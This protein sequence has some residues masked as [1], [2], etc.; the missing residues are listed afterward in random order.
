MQNAGQMRQ[1]GDVVFVLNVLDHIESFIAASAAG[2]VGTGNKIR[3]ERREL[4]DR[5]KK[6]LRTLF[7]FGRKKFKGVSFLFLI[8]NF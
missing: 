8:K 2:A 4:S 5:F 1:A 7:R 3:F 6:V